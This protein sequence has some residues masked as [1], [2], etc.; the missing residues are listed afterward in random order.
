AVK[1]AGS[2]L[3]LRHGELPRTLNYDY[4]DPLCRLPVA[5]EPMRLR[6]SVGMSVSRTAM[7]QSTAAV[8]RAV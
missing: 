5:R 2:I 3:A 1:L 4:P 8:F 7:G 6:S